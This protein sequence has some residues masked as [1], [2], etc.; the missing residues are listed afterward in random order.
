VLAELV[1]EEALR[2]RAAPGGWADGLE[3][4]AQGLAS[5]RL[6]APNRVV[7]LVW[8]G[9]AEEVELWAT[10]RGLAWHCSCGLSGATGYCSHAVAAS[11]V[12][13]EHG[14]RHSSVQRP[15]QRH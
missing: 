2:E 10:E 5:L 13:L 15:T 1:D 12:T 3:L 4:K 7:A 8:D 14:R 11:L 9:R 6:I